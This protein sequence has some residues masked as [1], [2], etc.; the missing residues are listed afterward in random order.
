MQDVSAR[1]ALRRQN[2][3][4]GVVSHN[5]AVR[6]HQDH[7]LSTGLDEQLDCVLDG[8]RIVLQICHGRQRQDFSRSWQAR[9]L[10]VV[11]SHSG[12][13]GPQ[14]LDNAR[15]YARHRARSRRLVS[16]RCFYKFQTF[17]LCVLEIRNP[18]GR[19]WTDEASQ[20]YAQSSID[21]VFL[22]SCSSTTK[23]GTQHSS[24]PPL[25]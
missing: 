2:A 7:H 5:T 11:Q 1:L 22:D 21:C 18:I 24:S 12:S 16:C 8:D 17:A 23:V 13:D 20:T 25:G 15:V 9:T 6:M 3:V 4:Q 10:D 19:E 14:L